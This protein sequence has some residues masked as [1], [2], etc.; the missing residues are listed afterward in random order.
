VPDFLSSVS[1]IFAKATAFTF[2]QR[3]F[4]AE[5]LDFQNGTLAAILAGDS[6]CR[7]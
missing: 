2:A 7:L 6:A 4:S 1:A 3:E 5:H